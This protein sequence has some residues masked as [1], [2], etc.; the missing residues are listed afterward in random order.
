MDGQTVLIVEDETSLARWLEMELEHEG[1]ACAAVSTGPQALTAVEDRD[2]DFVLLDLMLPYMDGFE[3]CR[4]LRAKTQ[5]AIIMV[6]ARDAIADKLAGFY[7]GADDYLVKPFAI[8]E[9]Q[10]R[11]RAFS[12]RSDARAPQA[13][14]R[15]LQLG[16]LCLDPSS[17][18]VTC[19]GRP[20]AL[21]KRE[22]DLLHYLMENMGIVCARSQILAAVWGYDFDAGTN[23]VDVYVRYLR[24]KL[25]SHIAAL[26]TVRGVGYALRQRTS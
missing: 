3:V 19:D 18:L 23:I 9:L 11:M 4:R 24:S 16:G 13:A 6:T 2:V 7:G 26:E 20:V 1:Y 22:F 21:T 5:A 12:R 17:R 25:G 10:A 14:R 15:V 8:E